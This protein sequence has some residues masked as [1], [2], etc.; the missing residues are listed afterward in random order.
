LILV[1]LH[2]PL[3]I[4]P[5]RPFAVVARAALKLT[6]PKSVSGSVRHALS[7]EHSD[8]ASTIHS[9]DRTST[10][11]TFSA[12]EN[13]P[14]RVRSVSFNVTWWP[15]TLTLALIVSPGL[16][17]IRIRRLGSGTSSYQAPE[18]DTPGRVQSSSVPIWSSAIKS[19]L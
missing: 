5:M 14:R 12:F 3:E 6:V 7:P 10:D 11:G 8:G 18:L 15:A 17:V 2:G 4:E 13:E 1:L 19:R 9:A 16:I